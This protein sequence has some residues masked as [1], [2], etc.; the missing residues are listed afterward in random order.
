LN[1]ESA[2]ASYW[3]AIQGC[4]TTSASDKQNAAATLTDRN[5]LL[6]LRR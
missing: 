1:D 5:L 4:D 6:N 2:P 3:D